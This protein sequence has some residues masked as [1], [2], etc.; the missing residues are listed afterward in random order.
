M[1]APDFGLLTM[2]API[3]SYPLFLLALSCL[4][5]H[6]AS[7]FYQMNFGHIPAL[8][9]CGS[10]KIRWIRFMKDFLKLISSV[11]AVFSLQLP[12][13]CQQLENS[14]NLCEPVWTC[15]NEYVSCKLTLTCMAVFPLHAFSSNKAQ[16]QLSLSALY[17][18]NPTMQS[19]CPEL[20]TRPNKANRQGKTFWS[21]F[22]KPS[23]VILDV[24]PKWAISHW[25]S[26]KCVCT[27]CAWNNYLLI[28]C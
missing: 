13:R 26:T 14:V 6:P 3:Q 8:K 17:A 18:G 10:D 1:C 7:I 28:I 11:K 23:W 20:H 15:V 19:H 4:W 9:V 5:P 27:A 2:L 22:F 24:S 21:I 25:W 12:C 16:P